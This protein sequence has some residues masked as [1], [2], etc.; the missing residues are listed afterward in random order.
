MDD[1][2][3]GGGAPPSPKRPRRK[4]RLQVPLDVLTSVGRDVIVQLAGVAN[5]KE[6]L[7]KLGVDFGAVIARLEPLVAEAQATETAR[8]IAKIRLKEAQ[9][10]AREVAARALDHVRTLRARVLYTQSTAPPAVGAHLDA[11]RAATRHRSSNLQAA[12]DTL[13]ALDTLSDTHWVPLRPY[14]AV[15]DL[16]AQIAASLAE[17]LQAREEVAAATL[18]VKLQVDAA[19]ALGGTLREALV[20]ATGGWAL[21]RHRVDPPLPSLLM[22]DIG[23]AV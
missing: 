7:E 15:E 4:G 13:L 10:S 20:A 6:D 23:V 5:R 2:A 14:L 16:Q 1:A 8:T 19:A 21:V 12:I 18:Q 3:S 11:V 9:A 22:R 17:V